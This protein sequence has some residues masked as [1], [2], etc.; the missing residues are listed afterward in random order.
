MLFEKGFCA[1]R[2]RRQYEEAGQEGNR[3][4]D[5]REDDPE[6]VRQVAGRD[7]GEAREDEDERRGDEYARSEQSD[8]AEDRNEGLPTLAASANCQDGEHG[9]PSEPDDGG[10]DV[11]DLERGVCP[12]HERAVTLPTAAAGEAEQRDAPQRWPYLIGAAIRTVARSP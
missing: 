11:E 9:R 6:V 12:G 2:L 8:F 3:S 4:T 7:Q 1:L 5:D 10:E